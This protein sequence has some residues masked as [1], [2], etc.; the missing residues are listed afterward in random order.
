QFIV[1]GEK[2]KYLAG[3]CNI[4]LEEAERIAKQEGIPYGKALDLLD[5][6]RFLAIVQK[7]VDERNTHLAKYE[8]IKQWRIVKS[9]FSQ[10]GGEL[11]PSLKVKRKVVHQKYKDLIDQMY[12]KEAVDALYNH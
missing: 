5:D 12:E 6:K 4:N 10:D 11:T 3:L 8:G 2:K 9:E 1:I 7:H